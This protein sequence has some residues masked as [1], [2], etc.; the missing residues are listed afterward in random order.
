MDLPEVREKRARIARFLRENGFNA[1]VLGRRDNFAWFTG[2]GENAVVKTS[3]NGFGILVITE[4]SLSLVAQVMDGPRI[5]EEELRG[6]D[7]EPVFLRWY[8]QSREEKVGALLKGKKVVSDFPIE[9]ARCLPR[10]ITALHYP[11]TAGEISKCRVI[12]RTTER[13]VAKVAREIAPGMREREVEAM[14]LSECSREGMSCD[15]LLVGSDERLVSYR[16]P[17]PTEKKIGRVV[18]L[19]PAARK[20]GLHANVTRMVSFE[21]PIP[22]DLARRH[23]AASRVAAAAILQCIPGRRFCDILEVQKSVFRATGF[24]EEWREHYQGGITGYVLCDP[25]L[26][27]DPR[28]VVGPNQVFD[29]FCTIAGAK[30]EELSMSAQSGPEVLSIGG[31]W[32][33]CSY[34]YDGR[35]VRLPQI[36][37][38]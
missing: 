27:M 10:E 8:E 16:H 26:S 25:T 23:E 13:I 3:E 28:S 9:G 21:D 18:L 19:H 33:L 29:W 12:G 4:D 2:G 37:R 30:V 22:E 17:V 11:L 36:L 6:L 34:E 38:R 32:P 35:E 5:V 31:D 14:L 15:V 1:L 24:A 7:V 20:W